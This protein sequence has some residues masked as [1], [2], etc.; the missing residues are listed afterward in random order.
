[1]NVISK[2]I[3]MSSIDK[4][5]T[6]FYAALEGLKEVHTREELD[7]Q[8]KI[9]D[10]SKNLLLKIDPEF[11]LMTE[12]NKRKRKIESDK[13]R[14]E[15]RAKSSEVE[16]KASFIRARAEAARRES[17]KQIDNWVKTK[18]VKKRSLK[19][20][21]D[22]IKFNQT[23]TISN[24]ICPICG[25]SDKGNFVNGVPTCMICMHKLVIKSDL[26]KYNRKYRR[27]WNR[28]GNKF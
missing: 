19:E 5:R 9:V 27:S 11:K 20:F 22:Q 24:L 4:A 2:R 7:I 18:I 16:S 26:K 21:K 1:M 28:R 23:N 14:A 6:Q 10:E 13:I 12:E 15:Y 8:R 25:D 17:E 3:K